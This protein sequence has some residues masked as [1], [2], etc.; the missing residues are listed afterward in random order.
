M[1][2]D[3]ENAAILVKNP[4]ETSVSFWC[5]SC[6]RDRDVKDRVMKIVIK[7]GISYKLARC[8]F[9]KTRPLQGGQPNP[10]ASE[11]HC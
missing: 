6:A 8:K 4:P 9:C 11:A 10:V 3:A 7:L 1:K 2:T 5:A